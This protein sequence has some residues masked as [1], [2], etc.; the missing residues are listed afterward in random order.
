MA[1]VFGTTG[2]FS[3]FRKTRWR[4]ARS[5]CLFCVVFHERCFFGTQPNDPF[6]GDLETN[7]TLRR[8]K[9][10]GHD[11]YDLWAQFIASHD[12]RLRGIPGTF[13]TSCWWSNCRLLTV[14]GFLAG[15]PLLFRRKL[16]DGRTPS[17]VVSAVDGDVYFCRREIHALFHSSPAAVLITAAIEFVYRQLVRRKPDPVVRR[18]WP[19][20]LRAR[21]VGLVV[22]VGSFRAAASLEPSLPALHQRPGRRLC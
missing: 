12:E 4:S 5:A 2:C 21:R 18:P 16:G 8:Q 10:I 3:E 15:L 14:A 13:I 19:R 22:V 20:G 17:H 6:A 7:G 1:I 9:L 11:G